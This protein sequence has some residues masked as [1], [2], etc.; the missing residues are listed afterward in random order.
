[1]G[2]YSYKSPDV[3]IKPERKV[4]QTNTEIPPP[5]IASQGM[6]LHAK[7]SFPN[8]YL[9]LVPSVMVNLTFVLIQIF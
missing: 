3:Q 4:A 6:V 8:Q 2:I 9:I 7:F 1:M 5:Y